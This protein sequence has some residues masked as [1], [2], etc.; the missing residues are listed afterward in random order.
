MVKVGIHVLYGNFA[1][2]SRSFDDSEDDIIMPE[3]PHVSM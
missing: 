2:V 3:E 1:F